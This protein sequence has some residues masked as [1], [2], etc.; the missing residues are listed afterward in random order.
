M[1][2]NW[3][4]NQ[5]GKGTDKTPQG[6]NATV[7]Y[8]ANIVYSKITVETGTPVKNTSH[9]HYIYSTVLGAA[10]KGKQYSGITV[11]SGTPIKSV[12]ITLNIFT[13]ELHIT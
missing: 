8:T 2:C 1:Q 10:T 13:V 9:T 5:N 3:K 12:R 11:E 6:F 7:L 4:G